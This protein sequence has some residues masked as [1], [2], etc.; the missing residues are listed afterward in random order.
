ME[1]SAIFASTD[2]AINFLST[3]SIVNS[4]IMRGEYLPVPKYANVK[5]TFM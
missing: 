1:I 5:D 4:C 3:V 2:L